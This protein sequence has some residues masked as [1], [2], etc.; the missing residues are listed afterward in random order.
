VLFR[1]LKSTPI[2]IRQFSLTM[3]LQRVAQNQFVFA[4]WIRHRFPIFA[5]HGIEPM[6]GHLLQPAIYPVQHLNAPCAKRGSL[7]ITEAD[8]FL[9]TMSFSGIERRVSFEFSGVGMNPEEGLRIFNIRLQECVCVIVVQL[10]AVAESARRQ[11][12]RPVKCPFR[13]YCFR[14]IVVHFQIDGDFQ[15]TLMALWIE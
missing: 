2:E 15:A 13:P 11:Q 10:R 8:R 7:K 12:V 5:Q 4:A 1:T 9:G 14:D 6:G 3:E